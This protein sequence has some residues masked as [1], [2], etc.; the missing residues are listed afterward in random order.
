MV[1][2]AAILA[3]LPR[4]RAAEPFFL[5]VSG[6]TGSS[7]TLEF[8]EGRSADL[9]LTLTAATVIEPELTA[10]I[11]LIGGSLVVP[12]AKGITPN[13]A[14]IGA[15]HAGV[16][17]FRFALD[18][19]ASSKSQ[20]L[21][22]R[23]HVRTASAEKWLPLPAVTMVTHPRTWA[24]TLQ[25]FAR[26]HVSGRLAGSERLD[27]LCLQAGI[28]Q[29]ENTDDPVEP[30][31]ARIW[32]ADAGEAE[33]LLPEAPGSTIWVVFKRDVSGGM[34]LRRLPP[35]GLPCLL[36]DDRVLTSVDTDV[37]A[38]ILFERSLAFAGTLAVPQPD[39]PS[40]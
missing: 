10:D 25:Q 17:R 6:E 5:S 23:M 38:Q 18:I 13:L 33:L 24:K 28:E 3:L 8:M 31:H 21:I 9:V 12:L 32:F 26:R 14:C 16:Q 19:P 15:S 36:V 11:F 40:P 30:T 2:L 29:I 1:M 34:E 22:L 7:A 35:H 27:K 39:S 4:A 37:S 20:K